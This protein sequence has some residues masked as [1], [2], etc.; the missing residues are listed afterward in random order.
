MRKYVDRKGGVEVE[1]HDTSISMTENVQIQ[2][3]KARNT[4]PQ[5]IEAACVIDT[6]ISYQVPTVGSNSAENGGSTCVVCGTQTA[7][8]N[9]HFC[10]ECWKKYKKEMIEGIKEAL[11]DTE[12]EIE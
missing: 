5:K 8:D 10:V 9:R 2:K 1:K 6:A 3:A 4:A 12:I 7:Y 11:A